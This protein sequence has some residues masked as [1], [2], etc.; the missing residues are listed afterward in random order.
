MRAMGL[1]NRDQMP[2]YVCLIGQPGGPS[3]LR[4]PRTRWQAAPG[5]CQQALIPRDNVS[6]IPLPAPSMDATWPRVGFP[7]A[8]TLLK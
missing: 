6:H 2:Y 5:P 4:A 1:P 7:G 8:W 3:T